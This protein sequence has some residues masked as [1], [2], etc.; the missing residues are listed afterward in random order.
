MEIF[1]QQREDHLELVV[2]GRLDGYWAQHLSSTVSNVLRE[3][4][5]TVRLNLAGATYISSA[6]IGVLVDLH[7]QFAEVGGACLVTEPSRAVSKVIEMVGLTRLLTTPGP[8]GAQSRQTTR[9]EIGGASF[10]LH[11]LGPAARLACTLTGRP[12]L[13][14]AAAYTAADCRDLSVGD[15]AFSLGLGAFGDDFNTARDRFGEFLAISGAAATQPT[16]GTNFPDYMLASGAFVPR[17]ATLYALSCEGAFGTLVRFEGAD[18][19]TLS[20]LL[21]VCVEAC[22]APTAGVVLLAESAGLVGATLKRPPVNGERPFTFPGIR[23][24]LSF[25]AERCFT[26][27]LALAA[28]IVTSAPSPA[29]ARFV[30]PLTP[31]AAFSAHMHA[32]AFPYRPLPKGALDLERTVRDLF[33]AGGLQG[34][35]HLL[36]D[37]RELHGAGESE[38]LRGACWVSPITEVRAEEA[39]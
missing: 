21:S 24:W 18:P 13:L 5:H 3:G 8:A 33:E 22:G 20:A 7:K 34:V 38:F 31:G 10:E 12:Q 6:G 29:L 37:T 11:P 23:D 19:V 4:A 17:L 16:D 1:R 35:L 39:A 15:S 30:R 32:A 36:A 26:R 28:G 2:A 14:P 9:R 25:S 27:S